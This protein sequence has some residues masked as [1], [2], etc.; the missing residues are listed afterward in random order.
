MSRASDSNRNRLF[1]TKRTKSQRK[2]RGMFLEPLERRELMAV[3]DDQDTSGFTFTSGFNTG[4]FIGYN[5]YMHYANGDSSGDKATWTF[6]GLSAGT[7]RVAATWPAASNAASNA[8]F[9]VKS[10]GN[11]LATE[12]VDQRVA[13]DDSQVSGT[14]WEDL[15][16]G[17]YTIAG[18]D[19]TVEVSDQATGFVRAD[20]VR[21]DPWTGPEAHI[22]TGGA[23]VEDN[24]GS[25]DFGTAASWWN[26]EKTFT[27]KNV[28]VGSALSLGTLTVPSGFTLVSGVSSSTLQPGESTTFT[29]RLDT[30]T[31]GTKS[32][33][34][35]LVTNDGNENPYNFA[36]NG[37][38]NAFQVIDDMDP[39]GFTYTSGFN[40][41]AF[42]GYNTYRHHAN[43]DGTGDKATWTFANV[44]DGTY[45]V[46]ATWN[47]SSSNSPAAAY[48]VR[49]GSTVLGTATAN[50]TIAPND[51][52]IS[53][54]WWEDL[55]TGVFTV[56][57]G[58]V[59]VE[60]SDRMPGTNPWVYAIAD[61]VRLEP[62]SGPEVNVT[63]GGLKLDD[64]NGAVD[65]GTIPNWSSTAKTF[66]VQ[67][68]GTSSALS[69]GTLTIPSGFTLVSGLGSTTLQPGQSTTFSVRLDTA[70]A[71]TKSGQ[72][73]LVTNDGNENPFNFAVTGVV[74]AYQIADDLD[75]SSFTY[76]SGFGT[77]G[78][79]GYASYMHYGNGDSSGDKATWTFN[80]LPLGSYRISATWPAASYAT[81][82]A[83]FTIRANGVTIGTNSQNQQVAPN[84][85]QSAGV[86]WEDLAPPRSWSARIR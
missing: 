2:L 31:A 36:V 81:T 77:G 84:D 18:G 75:S 47:A 76:T 17:V 21:I 33:Q 34:I 5:S 73:S 52:Q 38:V 7:Y 27:V 8:P 3:I 40:S 66:T 74:N 32:G 30:A 42:V 79:I 64:D 63:L 80:N 14:W 55:G 26:V 4:G 9:T 28:G 22:T 25:V 53:G 48:T 46:S 45:R 58:T 69:L 71:G 56:S 20:A 65:F 62:W 1:A 15:G 29:V 67:N 37:V 43:S 57:G 12:I 70:T 78:G 85:F 68:V 44:P 59:S 19:L 86:W 23:K 35:S 11:V 83:P 16:T 82:A 50:Q 13:P 39:S 51:A 61:A 24:T 60:L 41:G 49:A 10:G 6:T 54:T 72:I